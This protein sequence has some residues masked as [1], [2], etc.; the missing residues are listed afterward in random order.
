MGLVASGLLS[1]VAACFGMKAFLGQLFSSHAQGDT[2]IE[3]DENRALA[4][5]Q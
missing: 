1:S 3:R 5:L 4:T 2:G